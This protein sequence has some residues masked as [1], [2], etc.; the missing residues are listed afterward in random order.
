MAQRVT[1]D[2][3]FDVIVVGYGFAGAFTAI[4]AADAGARVLLAEKQPDPGGI[5]ICSYGSMRCAHDADEAYAY[6]TVTNAGR[7]PDD[8]VRVLADGMTEIEAYVRELAKV[9]NAKVEIRENGGNYPFPGERTFYDT[10]VTA[11]PGYDDPRVAYPHVVGGRSGNG[12][13]VFR[14][15]EDNIARRNITVRCGFAAERLIADEARE[16]RGV[17]FR[18]ASGRRIAV[19]ARRGVVLACGGFEASAAMKEQYWEKTPVLS[20][21][22]MGNTGDGIRMAQELGAE[23]WH[24]WHYHGAHGFKHPDPKYPFALR[25]KNLP[26]WVPG[27]E[28]GQPVKMCWIVVDRDGRR[29]MNE[30]PPY[31]QDIVHRPMEFYDSVRQMFPRIP[32]LLIY[33]ENG[34]KMYPIGQAIYNQRGLD[35]EWSDDNL[36]EIELGIIKKAETVD[37]L[38]RRIGAAPEVL[39]ATIER[40][41]G[42]CARG[43]DEDFGRPSGTMMPL[44]TPP[45]YVGEVWP[46]VSN[47]QGGPVHNA[48]QQIVNTFGETIPRLY[49]AGELGSAMG[50][51]YLAAA[52]L[53]ECVIG[54]RIAGREAAALAPWD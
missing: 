10:N 54:G 19:K 36:R 44:D 48:R 4:N 31:A 5:S 40:W 24:M 30:Y 1:F 52:N 34:R 20:V 37:A 23:L 12:W 49:S 26:N 38:A 25:A 27:R 29:Y 15:L 14:M 17:W 3:E 42:L 13:R 45:Y 53:S 43:A 8:V 11:V 22:T 21:A 39:R 51:L 33:D 46:M 2:E 35:Y 28:R 32:S 18:D 7:T 6:L 47:T 50:F 16:V 41:N 9:S